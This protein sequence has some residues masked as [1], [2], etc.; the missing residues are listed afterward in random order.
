MNIDEETLLEIEDYISALD[1]GFGLTAETM[2]DIRKA[3]QKRRVELQ[4]CDVC[5]SE[6]I[7]EYSGMGVNCNYCNPLFL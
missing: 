7:T 2:A 4:S 3:I 1:E 6:D 5:G